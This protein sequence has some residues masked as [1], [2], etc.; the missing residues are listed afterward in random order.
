MLP[1]VGRLGLKEDTVRKGAKTYG[2][3]SAP[4]CQ[5][6]R[7][8]SAGAKTLWSGCRLMQ[9]QVSRLAHRLMNQPGLKRM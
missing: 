3:V 6:N 8:C 1:L 4:N 2:L 9:A 5:T 7:S